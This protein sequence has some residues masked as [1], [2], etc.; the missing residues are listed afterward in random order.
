MDRKTI[1]GQDT[2]GYQLGV[3]QNVA[4]NLVNIWGDFSLYVISRFMIAIR[5]CRH[6]A[7]LVDLFTIYPL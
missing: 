1:Y 2:V 5:T 6:S 3:D 4:E 7:L